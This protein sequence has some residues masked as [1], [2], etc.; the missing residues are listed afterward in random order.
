M[1][2]G[3]VMHDMTQDALALALS[4]NQVQRLFHVRQRRLITTLSVHTRCSDAS[5]TSKTDGGESIGIAM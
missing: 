4:S 2:S 3:I 1:L 5:F